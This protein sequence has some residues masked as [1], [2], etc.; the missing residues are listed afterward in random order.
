MGNKYKED[1]YQLNVNKK[2]YQDIEREI[3]DKIYRKGIHLNKGSQK[4]LDIHR[5]DIGVK[6]I[7]NLLNS[8]YE[9][10]MNERLNL[11]IYDNIIKLRYIQNNINYH[12]EFVLYEEDSPITSSSNISLKKETNDFEKSM[13]IS[14]TSK[15]ISQEENNSIMSSKN[16]EIEI[17]EKVPTFSQKFQNFN[18]NNF[19]KC[20]GK[21]KNDIYPKNEKKEVSGFNISNKKKK[22]TKNNRKEESDVDNNYSNGNQSERIY[23]KKYY[24]IESS[25]TESKEPK[26]EEP[27]KIYKR[28]KIQDINE[29]KESRN[30][31]TISSK[32]YTNFLDNNYSDTDI[33]EQNNISIESPKYTNDINN[34]NYNRP[35]G[36]NDI[37]DDDDIDED[38]TSEYSNDDISINNNNQSECVEE[39]QD[40][41]MIE[42]SSKK[43]PVFKIEIDVKKLRKEDIMKKI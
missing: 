12:D 10:K 7:A 29:Q 31:Y 33:N 43:K 32:K 41:F 38:I 15:S 26:I 19:G 27:K 9:Q 39:I 5:K 1:D 11:T 20:R 18:K 6:N 42:G 3:K 14:N 21:M 30:N 13:E 36:F 40:A 8:I 2:L 23:N 25:L 35:N 17:E 22:I 24:I 34:S 37:D 16:T 4:K 28:K